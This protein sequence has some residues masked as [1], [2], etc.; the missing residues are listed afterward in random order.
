MKAQET[1]PEIVAVKL[2]KKGKPYYT[3]KVEVPIS[4]S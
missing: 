2:Y 1:H 4:T 3:T